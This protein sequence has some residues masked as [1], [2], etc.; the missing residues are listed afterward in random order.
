MLLAEEIENASV[1]VPK[2][3]IWAFILNIPF[4]FGL[5]LSYLFSMPDVQASI[6]SPTG[7]PFIY[8]FHQ[9]L[10]NTAGST[11]LVVVI[12]VLLIMITISSLASASRQTFAFA[13]DNGLPFSTWLGYVSSTDRLI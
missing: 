7:F 5:L 1:V 11:V 6:D 9:A 10:K 3:M 13:R 8:V 4:A 12:L 2:S